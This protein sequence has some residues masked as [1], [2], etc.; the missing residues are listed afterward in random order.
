MKTVLATGGNGGIGK[1]TARDLPSMAE[2]SFNA[3]GKCREGRAE[4]DFS[5]CHASGAGLA[6]KIYQ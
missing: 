2:N 4:F 5:G 1:A 3:D 6:R